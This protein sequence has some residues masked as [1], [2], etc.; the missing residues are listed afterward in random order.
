MKTALGFVLVLAHVALFL[1]LA[2]RCRGTSFEVEVDAPLASPALALEAKLPD[3]I[4]SRVAT[5]LEQAPPG[6]ARR[7]WSVRYRGGYARSIGAAQLVGP[8]QDPAN[9]ACSG[10]VV[11]GQPLLDA[12]AAPMQK[13]LEAELKGEGFVGIGDFVRVKNLKL[14]WAQAASH[15]EDKFV[16]SAP[17]GYVRAT[18][19]L[20][21]QRV[22]VPLT[23]ALLPEVKPGEVKFA[24]LARAELEFGNRFVQ[25]VS[26]RLGGDKLA[27]RF[28]RR[29][30]DSAIVT[31]LQPPPPFDVGG[32][33]I[34]FAYCDGVPEIVEGSY[35]ALP[36]G[37]VIGR[38]D[39][40]PTVLPP[41][42][43]IAQRRPIS[44]TA[45][46][47]LDLDLDALNA[48]LYELW[49]SGY[50]D[51]RLAAAGLDRR[52]NTDPIVTEFLSVRIS[53]PRLALPPVLS[54][55]PPGLRLAAD[56]RVAIA[57]GALRTV[58]RVWGGIDFTFGDDASPIAAD[59]GALELSC[60]K[61]PTR[62]VPCYA[63]LVNAIRDRGADFHGELTQTFASLLSDI[64]VEQRLSDSALPVVLVIKRAT[65]S[66]MATAENA[67][68]HVDLD[69]ELVAAP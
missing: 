12:F 66:V 33:T 47:A 38:V 23:V 5:T 1:V 53:A 29:E 57:D 44:P 26:D 49:R 18:A 50:L 35:G 7:T 24:I 45:A 67:S 54:T 2:S 43:G 11:V 42:R 22:D 40:D 31:A 58:G 28:T 19:T 63:D 36:F 46:L 15:P 61:T 9:I 27:T 10:R 60:E 65:P 17:H 55:K 30:I 37:I 59:L 52:F 56:A 41:R 62:L 34:T 3:G 16:K 4:A 20:A 48:L 6:L 64:F 8:F 69:A 51:Q 14:R 25:W 68:L 21:F 13:T 39:R 32:H